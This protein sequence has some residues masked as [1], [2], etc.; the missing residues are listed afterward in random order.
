VPN[1]PEIAPKVVDLL[2]AI[3]ACGGEAMGSHL[4][5]TCHLTKP[6]LKRQLNWMEKQDL[7]NQVHSG[8][9]RTWV[10][11]TVDGRAALERALER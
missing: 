3:V 8:D 2:A 1:T 7:V 5:E 6:Q 10:R 9:G 11:A 4:I